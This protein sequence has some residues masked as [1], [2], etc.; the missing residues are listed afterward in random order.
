DERVQGHIALDAPSMQ[1]RHDLR[2]VGTVE[3]I[4]AD[5]GVVTL[6]AEVDGVGA[7]LDRGEQAG[8]IPRRGQQLGLGAWPRRVRR[9]PGQGADRGP[10]PILLRRCHAEPR[11]SLTW[12]PLLR[13]YSSVTG[14]QGFSTTGLSREITARSISA[15]A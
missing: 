1:H 5:P 8:P 6:E 7:I 12:G 14:D 2:Q 15:W 3:V 10:C 4:R 11:D 9:P 13:S